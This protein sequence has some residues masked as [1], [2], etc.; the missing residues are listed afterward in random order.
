MALKAFISPPL[1]TLKIMFKLYGLEEGS[2]R[3]MPLSTWSVSLPPFICSCSHLEV[4]W[5]FP[6]Q[7]VFWLCGPGPALP[8]SLPSASTCV[9]RA[10][11]SSSPRRL[12]NAPDS[13]WP[14][15]DFVFTWIICM[16]YCIAS[17]LKG[18][19]SR[20]ITVP[21]MPSVIFSILERVRPRKARQL[22]LYLEVLE[23]P[24]LKDFTNEGWLSESTFFIKRHWFY[25]Y[26]WWKVMESNYKQ[27]AIQTICRNEA[28]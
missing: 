16:S 22:P 11:G 25:Y 17:S 28:N 3:T 14:S 9:L 2:S 10:L 5:F 8:Y 1:G 18:G 7:T 13:P 4:M 27:L 23:S 24:V 6:Y 20:F 12:S 15:Q 26:I 21:L 19:P